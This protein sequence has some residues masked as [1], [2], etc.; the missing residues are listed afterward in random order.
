MAYVLLQV[1]SRMDRITVTEV[2][3]HMGYV[4]VLGIMSMVA[5]MCFL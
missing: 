1:V 5:H 2:N 3:G 4:Y